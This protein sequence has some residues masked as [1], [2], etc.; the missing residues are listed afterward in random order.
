MSLGG[1]AADSAHQPRAVAASAS[2]AGTSASRASS[3]ARNSEVE[4]SPRT[5]AGRRRRV[6]VERG[7]R[8]RG[9]Y[10]EGDGSARWEW[11][12]GGGGGGERGR[13]GR[14]RR[15]RARREREGRCDRG[16]GNRE[17]RVRR[18][19]RR[20]W[21]ARGGIDGQSAEAPQ[22][23]DEGRWER[24]RIGEN[25]ARR[26]SRGGRGVRRALGWSQ[27]GVEP[28]RRTGWERIGKETWD[29]QSISHDWK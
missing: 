10:V 28:S 27:R 13:R 14:R 11:E 16:G 5:A 9:W 24:C 29:D 26:R 2:C 22:G 19:R 4:G 25:T 7:R 23:R 6:G 15:T 1:G 8:A 3:D 21:F 17:R 20:G 18:G 12:S